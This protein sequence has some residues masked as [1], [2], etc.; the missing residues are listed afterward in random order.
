MKDLP[1]LSDDSIQ[2]MTKRCR[3]NKRF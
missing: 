3:R 2:K 1:R